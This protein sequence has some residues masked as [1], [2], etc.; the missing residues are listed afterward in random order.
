MLACPLVALLSPLDIKK[1]MDLITAGLVDKYVCVD[2]C[3]VAS[4][5]R[6]N[7]TVEFCILKEDMKRLMSK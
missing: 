2:D 4:V 1:S 7:T 3:L 5:L 6:K